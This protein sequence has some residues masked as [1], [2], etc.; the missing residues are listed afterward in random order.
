MR[1][2]YDIL[3]ERANVY[4]PSKRIVIP[5]FVPPPNFAEDVYLC[6][7]GHELV[8]RTSKPK[9]YTGKVSCDYCKEEPNVADG[10]YHCSIDKTDYHKEHVSHLKKK[11][12]SESNTFMKVLLTTVVQ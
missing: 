11:K 3:Q 7:N 4:F 2:I 5:M 12:V 10:F 9:D 6:E 1:Y 8:L